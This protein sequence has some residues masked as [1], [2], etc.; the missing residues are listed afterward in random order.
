[1]QAQQLYSLQLQANEFESKYQADHPKLINIRNQV[2]EAEA[3]YRKKESKS[4]EITDDLNPIHRKLTLDLLESEAEKAGI[5]AKMKNL[6]SQKEQVLENIRDLNQHEIVITDL[7][8]ERGVREAKYISYTNSLEE[9]RLNLELDASRISSIVTQQDATLEEKPVSPSKLLVCVF[10]VGLILAG[11]C[12]L[13]FLIVKF[14]DRLTTPD[15]VRERTGLPVL[16]TLPKT[17]S[18]A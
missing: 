13:A 10:G 9:A 17:K 14:D 8:R 7:E 1:M 4:Q 18:L 5:Q 6:L 15:S 12:C 16:C 3:N 2:R 11:S